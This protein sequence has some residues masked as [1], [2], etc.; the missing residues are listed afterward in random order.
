M[1]RAELHRSK[2]RKRRKRRPVLV[3]LVAFCCSSAWAQDGD[4]A[5]LNPTFYWHGSTANDSHWPALVGEGVL[6]NRGGVSVPGKPTF[7]ENTNQYFHGGVI[8]QLSDSFVWLTEAKITGT[9]NANRWVV[10]NG[11]ITPVVNNEIALNTT[12]LRGFNFFIRDSASTTINCNGTNIIASNATAI[13]ACRWMADTKV[14]ALFVNGAKYNEITN[15]LMLATDTEDDFALGVRKQN[16]AMTQPFGGVINRF[17][18]IKGAHGDIRA[19]FNDGELLRI[20]NAR[21]VEANR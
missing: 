3:A 8:V 12:T 14:A 16:G 7:A 17:A 1:R 20:T 2:R 6:T 9:T 11:D 10:F 4:W 15:T 5:T 13:V 19:R 18:A 21:D